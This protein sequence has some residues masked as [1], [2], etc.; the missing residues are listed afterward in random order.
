MINPLDDP[1]SISSPREEPMGTSGG[2]RWAGWARGLMGTTGF[3]IGLVLVVLVAVFSLASENHVFFQLSNFKNMGLD[4]AVLVLLATG[5]TYVIGAGQLDLSIGANL[6]LS[7]V[8]ASLAMARVGGESAQT[9]LGEYPN[10]TMALVV[11]VIAA[12]GTGA[13][14]GLVNGLLVTRAGLSSFIVTLATTGIGTGLAYVLTGGSD[15]HSLPGDLQTAFGNH[16]IFGFL[17]LPG[18]IVGVVFLI[19]W[20]VLRATVFGQRTLAIGSSREAADRA[21]VATGRHLLSLF[22]LMGILAG[23]GG[24][25]DVSR[26][27]TTNISGHQTDALAAISAVVIGGTSLYGGR[28]SLPG[29]LIGC[30]I[31][32]VLVTGLVILGVPAFYQLIVVGCILLGAVLVDRRRLGR[33][34]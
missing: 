26:F 18:V 20:Y 15:L 11:G 5:M 16:S 29:S 28:A 17:A 9:D 7:S 31:P 24:F 23:L 2:T 1:A 4:A 27:L 22:M 21:G 34:T 25:L 14:F 8:V 13:I 30:L 33:Q 6:L 12:L 3:W 19:F 10:L 32:V